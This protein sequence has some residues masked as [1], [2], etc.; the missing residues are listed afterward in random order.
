MC[1]H[2]L[3]SPRKAPRA[4]PRARPFS[5][6][7]HLPTLP[8]PP[9]PLNTHAKPWGHLSHTPGAA[10]RTTW[11]RVVAPGVPNVLAQL[12]NTARVATVADP[13]AVEQGARRPPVCVQDPILRK[14]EWTG[15]RCAREAGVPGRLWLEWSVRPE[16]VASAERGDAWTRAP[17]DLGLRKGGGDGPSSCEVTR[18]KPLCLPQTPALPLGETEARQVLPL[19]Q[20]A[21]VPSGLCR[22][23]A[24]VAGD[25]ES[26]HHP[27]APRVPPPAGVGPT[28]ALS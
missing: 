2:V 17:A 11:T 18:G 13:P 5:K 9:H 14:Q 26:E 10:S 24:S 25:R 19:L 15:G 6:A 4:Q 28:C 8:S 12:W 27:R 23:P 20:P 7:A 22:V 1:V 16:Q 3:V 21:R